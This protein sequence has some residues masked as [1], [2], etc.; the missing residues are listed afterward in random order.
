MGRSVETAGET[1]L[2][3]DDIRRAAERIA[4]YAKRT[5]VL[6]SSSIDEITGASLFFKCENFQT[7][8]AFKFRGAVN[9]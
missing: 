9:A 3:L 1:P 4:P 5:P 7:V 8:G 6:R 2:S